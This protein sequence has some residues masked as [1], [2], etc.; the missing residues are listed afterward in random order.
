MRGERENDNERLSGTNGTFAQEDEL[1]HQDII[2]HDREKIKGSERGRRLDDLE[3][4]VK[5]NDANGLKTKR[6]SRE[7]YPWEGGRRDV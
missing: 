7:R 6:E 2:C 5:R 4:T 1:E 3:L